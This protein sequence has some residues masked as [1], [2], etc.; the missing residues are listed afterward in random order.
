MT[1]EEI[2]TEL[3]SIQEQLTSDGEVDIDALEQRNGE[4][5]GI[6]KD[7]DEKAER[8]SSLLAAVGGAIDEGKAHKVEDYSSVKV[9]ERAEPG[10]DSEEY[11]RAWVK[12]MAL[13]AGLNLRDGE[14]SDIEQRAFT[15][16]TS[17]TGTVVPT[18]VEDSIWNLVDNGYAIYGDLNMSM[19]KNVFQINR[20]TAIAAGDAKA[21][22]EGVA[23]DDEQDTF[24]A[25]DITGEEFK[26]T[27]KI[28]RKMAV[29]S[30]AGFEMW[31][32]NEIA[33]RL[34]NAMDAHCITR[35]GDATLGMDSANKITTAGAGVLLESEVRKAF[36]LLGTDADGMAAAKGKV[37]YASSEVIWNNIAGLQDTTG[38][39]LFIQSQMDSDPLTQGRI[40]GCPVKEDPNV[41]AST[42]LIGYPGAFRGN[43]FDGPDITPFVDNG[44]QQ[45]CFTG[46]ALFDCGLAVP[47]AFAQITIKASA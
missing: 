29:Q 11:K 18:M 15:F 24:T 13:K 26:K 27:I 25:I 9:I 47:K 4:L 8:R 39:S 41:A 14:M 21:T 36:G 33:G 7:M 28:S 6:K 2:E 10:R 38:R 40:F 30:I 32:E 44:T 42:I 23:N 46:Y 17:N 20:M 12:D 45:H 34:G 5:M 19:F 16:T 1:Y 37:V 22:T 31:L 43:L 35:L 3:R